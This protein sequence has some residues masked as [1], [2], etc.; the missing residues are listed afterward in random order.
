[1]QLS[2]LRRYNLPDLA[3]HVIH[4]TG[5]QGNKLW[6]APEIGRLSDEERLAHILVDGR[7]QAFQTFRSG[8]PV[9]CLTESVRPAVSELI[10][11]RRYTPCGVGFSKDF[12]FGKGGGPA[13]YVRGDEWPDIEALPHPLRSRMIRFWPGATPDGGEF[14]PDHLSRPSEWLQERE[15][16]VAGDLTFSWEHVDFLIVPHDEWQDFYAEWISD[17]AGE[18]YAEAF[19]AIPA[20][21]MNDDGAVLQDGRGIWVR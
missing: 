20:V 5:R 15:W 21:V 9:V 8:A 12:V 1:V 11:Q 3:D 10:R 14:L 6:L 7:I 18:Q 4:F 13:L 16:R 19:L 17:W 2:P